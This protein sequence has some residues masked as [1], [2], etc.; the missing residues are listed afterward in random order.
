[1]RNIV[2]DIVHQNFPNL[3]REI[4]MEIQ[5]TPVKYYIRQPSPRHILIRFSKVNVKEKTSKAAREKEQAM[6]KGDLIRLTVD[7]SGA[8]L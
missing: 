8:T 2:E 6:Y 1:M 5:R 7:L 3:A 4:D